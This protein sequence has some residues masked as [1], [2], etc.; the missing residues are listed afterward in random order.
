MELHAQSEDYNRRTSGPK[1]FTGVSVPPPMLAKLKE[2]AQ[3]EERPV[4]AVIR[5]AIARY[6]ASEHGEATIT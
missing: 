2:R 3:L 4:S 5:R 1:V 6:L